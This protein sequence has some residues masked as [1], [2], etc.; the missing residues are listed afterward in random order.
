VLADVLPDQP[1]TSVR[2]ST[3][4]QRADPK[5]P[6]T[7]GQPNG[8]TDVDVVVVREGKNLTGRVL[9]LGLAIGG[10]RL[11]GKGA[12]KH[13]QGDRSPECRRDEF[14]MAEPNAHPVDRAGHAVEAHLNG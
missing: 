11:L 6:I 5:R 8:I 9:G 13:H 14:M 3:R 4:R 10:T 1:A 2:D 12:R 7:P